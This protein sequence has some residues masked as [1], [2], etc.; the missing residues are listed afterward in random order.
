MAGVKGAKL[1]KRALHGAPRKHYCPV[2]VGEAE[3]L[4]VDMEAKPTMQMPRRRIRF[5]CKAGHSYTRSGTLL[6]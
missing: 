3:E 2:C 5:C 1:A 6:A 4:T